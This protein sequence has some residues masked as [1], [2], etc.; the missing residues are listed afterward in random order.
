MKTFLH[1]IHPIQLVENLLQFPHS[2]TEICQEPNSQ[3]IEFYVLK[4]FDID[5]F[6]IRNYAND[7]L[8]CSLKCLICQPTRICKNS[9]TLIDH[10]YSN[11]MSNIVTSGIMCSDISDH[12]PIFVIASIK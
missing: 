11:N 6:Q 5:L 1:I 8:S 12:Q 4:N 10:I 3:N 2:I 9:K 7:L